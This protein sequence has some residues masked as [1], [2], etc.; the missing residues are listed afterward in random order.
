MSLSKAISSFWAWKQQ[1]KA[2]PF[3][4][5]DCQIW[6]CNGQVPTTVVEDA[7]LQEQSKFQ[8]Q[9][10]ERKRE[11]AGSIRSLVPGVP[12]A[13]LQASSPRDLQVSQH[14][15]HVT[16]ASLMW[17]NGPRQTNETWLL[18]AT[19]DLLSI[20]GA[21]TWLL[22]GDFTR[23]PI[24]RT[25]DYVRPVCAIRFQRREGWWWVGV[26]KES[27]EERSIWERP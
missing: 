25:K 11:W 3:R 27:Y 18:Q 9:E 7:S 5:L 2:A 22:Q 8:K 14:I 13:Y 24:L 1:R 15:P 4:W 23:E 21:R 16:H 17:D 20:W 12:E 6:A 26:L 19:G 10:M